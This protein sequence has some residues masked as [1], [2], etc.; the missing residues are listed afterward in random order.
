MYRPKSTTPQTPD[1]RAARAAPAGAPADKSA[2]AL[3]RPTR[4]FLPGTRGNL[5]DLQYELLDGVEV[6]E[7]VD[8]LPAELFADLLAQTWSTP[9]GP[10][11]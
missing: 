7:V 3:R 5:S 6:T 9:K 4:N 8:T 1:W 2:P 11:K 10:A